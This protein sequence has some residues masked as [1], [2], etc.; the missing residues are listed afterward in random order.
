MNLKYITFIITV[1]YFFI[2]CKAN[3]QTTVIKMQVIDESNSKIS[4]VNAELVRM[5]DSTTIGRNV[6]D[7]NGDIIFKTSTEKGVFFIKLSAIGYN[8]SKTSVFKLDEKN[9]LLPTTKLMFSNSLLKEINVSVKRIKP[10]FEK[11]AE[12]LTINV[13]NTNIGNN[14]YDLLNNAPGIIYG[15]AGTISLNGRPGTRV[16][17]DGK[18]LYFTG[19]NLD[20]YLRSLNLSLIQKVEIIS[21]PSSKY[22]AEGTGGL[23]NII[24]KTSTNY[25]ITGNVTSSYTQGRYS[26]LSESI[27]IYYKQKKLAIALSYSYS[28]NSSYEKANYFRLLQSGSKNSQFNQE[29]YSK[30]KGIGNLINFSADYDFNKTNSIGLNV[31]SN[32]YNE[33]IPQSNRNNIS[34]DNVI[35][36]ILISN[37]KTTN[38]LNNISV[39]F[40]Y[41]HRLD[42]NGTLYTINFDKTFYKNT[43]QYDYDILY[44]KDLNLQPNNQLD[45]SSRIPNHISPMSFRFDISLPINKVSKIESG[46]KLAFTNANND[47]E[48][49]NINFSFPSNLTNSKFKYNENIEAVYINYRTVI[50]K[51]HFS[52]G[53][54]AE[55][56]QGKGITDDYVGY[57]RSYLNIFPTLFSDYKFDKN[58]TLSLSLGRRIQRPSYRDLN[59]FT[60]LIDPYYYLEGN[61]GLKPQLSNYSELSYSIFSKYIFTVLMSK[62][63]DL[64]MQIPKVNTLLATTTLTK[65]NI[66]SYENIGLTAYIP[67]KLT[68]WWTNY[69]NMQYY[70]KQYKTSV[71]QDIYNNNNSSFRAT[72]SSSIEL[73]K[74][75][76]FDINGYY[77]SS[78]VQG[79]YKTNGYSNLNLGVKRSFGNVDVRFLWTD[80]LKTYKIRNLYDVDHQKIDLNQ[81]FDS[82][83]VGITV[84]YKF[85]SG[86]SLKNNKRSSNTEE[87]Q[88]L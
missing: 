55:M 37:N 18:I 30:I 64:I 14:S 79:V 86:N 40:N 29:I 11:D 48:Y 12:K 85:K 28:R 61:S 25:G 71:Y 21:N 8:N 82:K 27:S 2:T 42:T 44:Y 47:I 53:L 83:T 81:Y 62:T 45:F 54:R 9:L 75:I 13:E 46:G 52:A 31:K 56:T 51:L 43:A 26:K 1:L 73:P 3:A 34:T 49:Q 67:I 66:G 10:I 24:L 20:N 80:V 6:S 16:M 38:N 33:K 78:A 84:S 4:S 17:V 70:Y 60:Y 23:I 72:L 19:S 7:G 36:S 59:P 76:V 57:S 65:E 58:N 77:Q 35:D 22:D 88:R 5:S 74:K 41:T 32:I 39:N 15:N 68:K 69:L 50:G 87:Q 63:T